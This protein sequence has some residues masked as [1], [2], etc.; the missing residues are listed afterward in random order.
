MLTLGLRPMVSGSAEKTL[1]GLKEIVSD[2]EK[3]CSD[4]SESEK[5]VAALKNTMSDRHIV[6][7]KFNELLKEYRAD[8]LPKVVEGWDKM[9]EEQRKCVEQINN[10]FCGMHFVVGLADQASACMK[11]WENAVHGEKKV[12]SV[13]RKWW[14]WWMWN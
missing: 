14:C 2:I 12:G 13:S 11:V 5:L 6:E 10:F 3:V 7:K 4:G 8:V 9:N 1:D